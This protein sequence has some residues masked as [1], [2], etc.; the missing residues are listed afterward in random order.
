MAKKIVKAPSPMFSIRLSA[1][2]R[3]VLEKAATAEDRPLAYVAR[4]AIMEWLKEKGFM[5]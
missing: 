1:D 2:E 3:K 4:R 5:K